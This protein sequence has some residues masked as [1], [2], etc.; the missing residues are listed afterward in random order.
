VSIYNSQSYIAT[1]YLT[2]NMAHYAVLCRK[3]KTPVD[4]IW[5]VNVVNVLPGEYESSHTIESTCKYETW[6]F[7]TLCSV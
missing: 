4:G 2:L 6:W 1:K 7:I 3:V 5:L